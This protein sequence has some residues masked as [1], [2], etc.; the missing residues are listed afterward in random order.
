MIHVYNLWNLVMDCNLVLIKKY[1]DKAKN[2]LMQLKSKGTAAKA[3]MTAA[4]NH[5]SKND[6]NE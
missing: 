5:G 6:G 3:I 2:S 1:M 4:Y